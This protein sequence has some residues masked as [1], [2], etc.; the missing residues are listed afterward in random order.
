MP[1]VLN[2]VFQYIAL[3]RA[4]EGIAQ[5]QYD[6]NAALKR[7][8]YD[9]RNKPGAFGY[10]SNL[11]HLMHTYP[12]EHLLEVASGVPLKFDEAVIRAVLDAL[13]P[14]GLLCMWASDGHDPEGMDTERWY[15][16]QPGLARLS[17][18]SYVCI[19]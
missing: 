6:D 2:H 11:A 13:T 8:G 7:L 10:A 19:C 15:A 3:L 16:F 4:P 17:H 14:E 9:Y 5:A 18:I 12:L 1:E